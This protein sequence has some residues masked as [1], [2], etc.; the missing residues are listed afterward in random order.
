MAGENGYFEVL[1]RLN[2]LVDTAHAAAK[3]NSN[4]NAW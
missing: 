2:D 1:E 3:D 4:Q